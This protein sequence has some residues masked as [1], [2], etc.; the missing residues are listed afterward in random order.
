MTTKHTTL[1]PKILRILTILLIIVGLVLVCLFG[2]RLMHEARRARRMDFV[3]TG[4][5]DVEMLRGWMTIPHIA[6]IYRVPE[7]YLF[8]SLGVTAGEGYRRDSLSR[9]NSK[10]APGQPGYVIDQ[11]KAAIIQ[12]QAEHPE[13]ILTPIEPPPEGLPPWEMPPAPPGATP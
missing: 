8:A 2:M 5:T 13:V 7:D 9:L 4:A 6:R 10:L 12:Y 1:S 11:I 3:K